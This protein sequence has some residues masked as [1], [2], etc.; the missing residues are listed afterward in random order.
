MIKKKKKK[1]DIVSL[2]PFKIMPPS[3][4]TIIKLPVFCNSFLYVIFFAKSRSALWRRC[5]GTPQLEPGVARVRG[6]IA[7]KFTTILFFFFFFFFFLQTHDPDP[8][9]RVYQLFFVFV[10]LSLSV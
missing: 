8:G 4:T 7:P 2:S 9:F 3:V 10:F 5:P 1:T 6:G